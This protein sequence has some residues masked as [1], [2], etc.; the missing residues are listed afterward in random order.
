M[1]TGVANTNTFHVWLIICN[2]KNAIEYTSLWN[3]HLNYNIS[4]TRQGVKWLKLISPQPIY[5][6][7]TLMSYL[8]QKSAPATPIV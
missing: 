3:S 4:D 7:W 5:Q 6:H 8:A 1:K 2:C